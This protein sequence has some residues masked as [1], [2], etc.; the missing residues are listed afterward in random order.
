[1]KFG[2]NS[3][4]I[5]GSAGEIAG[6]GPKLHSVRHLPSLAA[7]ATR[8]SANFGHFAKFWHIGPIPLDFTNFADFNNFRTSAKSAKLG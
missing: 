6:G 8:H 1:M 7:A 2:G 4:N 3:R 5:E